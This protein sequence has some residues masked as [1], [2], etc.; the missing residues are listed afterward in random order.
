MSNELP[1]NPSPRRV[2]HNYT[3]ITPEQ[4]VEEAWVLR[5]SEH[6][7]F[8]LWPA[9]IVSGGDRPAASPKRI[10][11]FL[12]QGFLTIVQGEEERIYDLCTV[13]RRLITAMYKQGL[14]APYLPHFGELSRERLA[15]WARNK[16]P[17]NLRSGLSAQMP[18][19]F[20]P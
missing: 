12:K 1:V 7:D 15:G 6:G 13:S 20:V 9:P 8:S 19:A 17:G 2:R 5:Q 10:V 14:L 4:A 16:T 3:T 11:E 18:K